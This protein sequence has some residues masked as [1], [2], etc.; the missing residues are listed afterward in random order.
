M[1]S[2]IKQEFHKM[3]AGAHKGLIGKTGVIPA[4]SRRCKR[5]QT[6]INTTGTIVLGRFG[7]SN[8]LKPEELPV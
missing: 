5:E 6:P 7:V 8:E 2:K 1:S 4:R 3:E